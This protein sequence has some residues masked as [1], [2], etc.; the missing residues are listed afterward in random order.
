MTLEV[1]VDESPSNLSRDENAHAYRD[2]AKPDLD[3]VVVEGGLQ[4]LRKTGK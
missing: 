2:V 1:S 4:L 3:A